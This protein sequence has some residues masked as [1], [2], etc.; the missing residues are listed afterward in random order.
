MSAPVSNPSRVRLFKNERLE[1]LTLISPRTFALS[2]CVLLP[3]IGY[4]GWG[5]AAPLQAMA[6]S[7]A[8]LLGWTVFEYLMHRYLFHW[9]SEIPLV[10]WLV[11]LIH[12]NHHASPNDPMRGLMPLPVSI[13]VGALVWLAL[14]SAFGVVGTWSFLGFMI[15]YVIYDT[16]HYACHQWPM[17]SGLGG[18]L[19]R[20]HMRHHHVD[21]GGNFA[22][23]AIF[24]DHVF[25]S[26]ITSLK[27]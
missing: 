12:G 23:S 7:L 19:K 10:Q 13:G 26:K 22:I 3:M 9:Q 18:M 14:V 27:R 11:Y 2:W 16:V 25:R 17:R 15:G 5:T 8:G 6:M 4:V 1:K 20:H 21:E 24:L